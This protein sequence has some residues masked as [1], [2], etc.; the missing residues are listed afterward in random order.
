MKWKSQAKWTEIQKNNYDERAMEQCQE[1]ERKQTNEK[2]QKIITS[3]L[4][5]TSKMLIPDVRSLGSWGLKICGDGNSQGYDGSDVCTFGVDPGGAALMWRVSMGPWK[6]NCGKW[7]EH[8]YK[9]SHS[10]NRIETERN[11]KAIEERWWAIL[12]CCCWVAVVALDEPWAYFGGSSTLL[13]FINP[14]LPSPTLSWDA[15]PAGKGWIPYKGDLGGAGNEAK[16]MCHC[17]C[18]EATN[19]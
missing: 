3:K 17:R 9:K 10:S 12:R 1:N 11:V 7:L 13:E 14:G 6:K 8:D 5:E 2:E 18:C 15:R 19:V 4:K 16:K